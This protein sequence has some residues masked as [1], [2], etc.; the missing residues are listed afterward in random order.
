MGGSDNLQQALDIFT[1]LRTWYAAGRV[2]TPCNDKKIELALGWL[3]QLMGGTENL[4]K[5]LVIFTQ[6][7]TR[8]AGG[9]VN[10]PCDHKDIELALG[11]VLELKG[12][13][14]DLEQA[15]AIYTRLRTRAAGGLVNTPCGDKNIELSLG[16]ILQLKGGD[17]NLEQALAIYTR[18]RARMAG[19][20]ENTPCDDRDIELTLAS[21][22]IE[23]GNWAAFD[24][25]QL[26][27]RRFPGIEPH[28]CQSVRSLREL[29]ET[30]NLSPAHSRLLG[31]AI[32]SAVL[33]VEVG[34]MNASCL[35]QL[36]HC[37]RLLSCWPDALLNKRGI[38]HKDVSRL[39]TA[40]KFL[41]DT[42]DMM[43][44]SR[45]RLEKDQRWRARERKL[46]A[47]LS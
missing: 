23:Q 47:L 28:L 37:L 38:Q 4:E 14:Q 22:F 7:R 29:L 27:A 24:A 20:R 33:A 43:T 32:Q 12:D 21:F 25:L 46:L 39:S 42:A 44:P 17:Q 15:L 18:L 8:A 1:Q 31:Q 10:T 16:R 34:G 45:Q 26:A 30:Q 2:N 6:L 9:L 36:A 3:L 35:S 40:A 19:G 5:A 41:F 11:R 13:A